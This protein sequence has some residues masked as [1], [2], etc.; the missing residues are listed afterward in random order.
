MPE[1]A[2]RTP[3][4]ASHTKSSMLVTESTGAESGGTGTQGIKGDVHSVTWLSLLTHKASEESRMRRCA[5]HDDLQS[6]QGM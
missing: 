5:L 4:A 3:D 1:V 6:V 2:C